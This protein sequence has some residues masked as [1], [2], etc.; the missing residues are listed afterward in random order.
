M[1]VELRL[2]NISLLKRT[3]VQIQTDNARNSEIR[4]G[5]FEQENKRRIAN[6]Q[7]PLD[8]LITKINME[9]TFRNKIQGVFRG[10]EGDIMQEIT[11][12]DWLVDQIENHLKAI[13]VD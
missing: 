5:Q 3:I 11:D 9:T 10:D 1:Q 12:I 4:Q 6:H 2:I 13:G 7:K 8:E